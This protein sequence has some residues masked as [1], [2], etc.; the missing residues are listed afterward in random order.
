MRYSPRDEEKVVSRAFATSK[1]TV[2]WVRQNERL[3][4]AGVR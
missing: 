2:V 1:Q 3:R 4:G